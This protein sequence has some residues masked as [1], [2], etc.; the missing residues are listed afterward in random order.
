MELWTQKGLGLGHQAIQ[1]II[2]NL[3]NLRS[4]FFSKYIRSRINQ[5]TILFILCKTHANH[6][7]HLK[8]ISRQSSLAHI[9]KKG[10]QPCLYAP[11]NVWDVV[12]FNP[13][14]PSGWWNLDL[15]ESKRFAY[16]SHI[17]ITLYISSEKLFA[18]CC[19]QS[20]EHVSKPTHKSPLPWW[21]DWSHL[22]YQA[23][24]TNCYNFLLSKTYVP[25]AR[26][27]FSNLYQYAHE[28]ILDFLIYLPSRFMEC[29]R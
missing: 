19:G 10:P 3:S 1:S 15:L 7:E 20:V 8:S 14:S 12:R 24:Q 26:S 13:Q 27:R 17:L 6:E 29:A 18:L 21:I 9:Q 16:E 4:K 5:A 11:L 23:R 22:S 25:R 2:A 28:F